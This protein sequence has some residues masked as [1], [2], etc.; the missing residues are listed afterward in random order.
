MAPRWCPSLS[1]GCCEY[2]L[3]GCL[4][5]AVGTATADATVPIAVTNLALDP[6]FELTSRFDFVRPVPDA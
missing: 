1:G 6:T 4:N 5:A 3:V 2:Q